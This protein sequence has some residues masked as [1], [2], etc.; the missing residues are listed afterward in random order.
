MNLTKNG[1]NS[2]MLSIN[3]DKK[4]LISVSNYEQ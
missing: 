3:Y 1:L 4:Q 2:T